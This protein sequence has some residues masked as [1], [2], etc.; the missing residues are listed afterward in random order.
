[1][2]H[3]NSKSVKAA[4]FLSMASLFMFSSVALAQWKIDSV[5]GLPGGEIGA[6]LLLIVNGILALVGT[7]SVLFMVYGGARYLTSAGNEND[8]ESAKSTLKYAALGLVF[9]ALAYA[10]V[11]YIL[12]II[13]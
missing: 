11:K 1:M 9:S 2:F 10:I 4:V 13:K 5:P 8:I 12:S 7:L 6:I 3:K